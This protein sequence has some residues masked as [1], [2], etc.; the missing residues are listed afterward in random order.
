MK[1]SWPL[2]LLALAAGCAT[3]P[4]SPAIATPVDDSALLGDVLAGRVAAI[5]GDA[6]AAA[7][8]YFAALEQAPGDEALLE[9]ALLAALQAGQPERAILAARRADAAGHASPLA[10]LTLA[11]DDLARNRR[12][13]VIRRLKTFEGAPIERLSARILEAWAVAGGGDEEAALG[14]L[15]AEN[16]DSPLAR[17]TSHQQAMVLDHAGRTADA[18]AAYESAD[19]AGLRFAT[20]VV[21]HARLLERSG[22]AEDAAAL[23]QKGELAENPLV[24]FERR[25][26]DA[27]TRPPGPPRPAEGAALGLVTIASVL[28]GQA[29]PGF[30]TPIL[31][32][33]LILD[34]E[35]DTARLAFAEAMQDQGR[36]EESL[37]ALAL[38]S[39][40]APY[41]EAAGVQRA[42]L[43]YGQKKVEE[44]LA[45]ARSVG[46]SRA[47]QMAAADMLRSEERWTEAEAVYNAMIARIETPGERDWRLF[48]A[49]GA[50]RERLKRWPEAEA[51]LKRS[52]ELSPDRPEVLN[53][54]GYS[55]VD[56]GMNLDQGLAL[57][58]RAVTLAPDQ[59]FIIDSLGWAYFKLGDY[60]KAL[61]LLETATDM[62]P[63]NPT[64]NDHLG[65]VYW[66][67]GRR[68]EAQHQWKRALTLD[69]SPD[70]KSALEAKL[71]DGLPPAPKPPAQAAKT[72]P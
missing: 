35:L 25:R 6:A 50:A 7:D 71:K 68:L 39:P 54:L 27:K 49:R 4:R 16:G 1:L 62:E 64:I 65:D 9:S 36:T 26:M 10:H 58:E 43:L 11:A 28:S 63:Q 59:G 48:F 3:P 21:R 20:A 53:Y 2:A 30:I 56:Q 8:A 69:P 31:S 42:W 44:A 52:L 46:D 23:L 13:G 17:L 67:L 19:K 47:A 40:Q 14:V 57:I 15:R 55:W 33:A 29:E 51:D 5:K 12:S 24:V 61:D 22:R 37:A 34:P 32:L 70:E 38:I 18:I 41:G 72:T 66:R 45:V 60:A